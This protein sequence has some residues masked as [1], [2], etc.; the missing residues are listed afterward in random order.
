MSGLQQKN[1]MSFSQRHVKLQVG[2]KAL[3]SL[4]GFPRLDLITGLSPTQPIQKFLFPFSLF[5]FWK[6]EKEKDLLEDFF[7]LIMSK[8]NQKHC[9]LLVGFAYLV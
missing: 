4:M 2:C 7:I 1:G 9:G 3:S 5:F 6:K 8:K